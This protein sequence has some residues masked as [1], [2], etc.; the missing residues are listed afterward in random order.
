MDVSIIIVNYNTKQLLYDCLRSLYANTR[1]VTFEII[2]SD[3]NSTDGSIEMLKKDFPDVFV[4]ENYINLGFGKANNVAAKIAKGKYLFFLN[5]D[6][7]L[8]NNAVKFFFDFAEK[9]GSGI[10]GCLLMDAENNIVHSYEMFT[11]PLKGLFRT[12]IQCYQGLYSIT[13]IFRKKRTLINSEKLLIESPIQFIIGADLF[14]LSAD[15]SELKGFDENF[16]M[17]FED[18]DLCRRALKKNLKCDIL[19]DAKIVHLESKSSKIKA[20][21]IEFFENS[22]LFYS[23]RYY[24]F[25]QKL[26]INIFFVF[27]SVFR[28]FDFRF[29]FRERAEMF[30]NVA[31]SFNHRGSKL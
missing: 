26:F 25:Y 1:D 5:S 22:F 12:V 6:T 31:K 2:V 27:Y 23:H 17:Y 4:I 11:S 8:L 10:Y 16:F 30:L 9:R 24:S 20:K 18:E 13:T 21:K 28:F 29:S 7:I 14:I 3:N 19:T 15:F